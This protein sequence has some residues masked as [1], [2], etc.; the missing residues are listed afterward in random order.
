[1]EKK[2]NRRL[3]IL[4]LLLIVGLSAYLRLSGIT[5]GIES[6]YGHYI[7]FQPDEFIS[8]RGML[9]IRPLTG[10]MRAPDAYFEGTFNYY[11]WAVPEM[12][13]ELWGGAH[14][15]VGE[16][17]PAGQFKFILLSGRLMS[18]A[19][20]LATLILLFVIISEMTGQYLSAFLGAFLYG[21]FP[22]QVIYS[23]FM[24]NH[25]LSNLL[26][27][28]V[29]WLSMR[30]LKQRRW[31]LFAA[32]GVVSGLG[33]A[34]RYPVGIILTIPCLCVLFAAEAG[35]ET[36]YRRLQTA[37]LY[38]LSGPLWLLAGGFVI[39][40]FIG[41]PMLFLD[42]RSVIHAISSE[43]LSYVPPGAGR[44]FDLEPIWKYF[45]VLIPYAT[46]P[47]LWLVIYLAA[48][49]AV[50]RRS[51]SHIVLPLC[52]FTALYTYPMAKGYIIIFARQVMLLLPVF[53]IFVGLASGKIL[54]KLLK[55]PF[56][57]GLVAALLALL[58]LPT[59]LFDWAYGQAMQKRDVR[60]LLR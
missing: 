42:F 27:V 46:Y 18:V 51:L 35:N 43:T 55:R 60:D 56:L 52:L 10:K 31:W 4:S 23:H 21:I 5:W 26:C 28:L 25:V 47:V 7:N 34:T 48:L 49:Y 29:I 59:L 11:L 30:A 17:V 38:L 53:C 3:I 1:M 44:P 14:P 19:F 9:P 58:V 32:A 33:G 13:H 22:M 57:F 2:K 12:L 41:E 37:T 24:R 45:S 54:P 36:W 20:D 6:G 50:F 39:G 15:I 8:I 40:F 16:N